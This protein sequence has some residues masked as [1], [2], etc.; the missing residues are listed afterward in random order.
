MESS[1]LA[2]TPIKE[3]S[4]GLCVVRDTKEQILRPSFKGARPMRV[5][6][7][8]TETISGYYSLMLTRYFVAQPRQF[9]R[10]R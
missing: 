8:V 4:S 9:N 3:N 6:T 10:Y 1:N 2:L 7:P 5:V